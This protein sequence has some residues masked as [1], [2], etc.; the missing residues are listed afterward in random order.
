MEAHGPKLWK[1]SLGQMGPKMDLPDGPVLGLQALAALLRAQVW[2]SVPPPTH[3]MTAGYWALI[4]AQ[5][6]C[7]RPL[8]V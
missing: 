6:P 2:C 1:L 3:R 5:S 8:H 4:T 7:Q